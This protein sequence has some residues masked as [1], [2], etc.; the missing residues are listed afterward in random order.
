M[1]VCVV[2]RHTCGKE[3]PMFLFRHKSHINI[4]GPFIDMIKV[5]SQRV[6][7]YI[8]LMKIQYILSNA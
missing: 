4:F 5:S 6:G 1:K 3:F 8:M 7:T 2:I